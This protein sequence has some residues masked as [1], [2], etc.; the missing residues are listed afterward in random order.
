VEKTV[1]VICQ[2]TNYKSI[3]Q[4]RL[5]FPNKFQ[6]DVIKQYAGARIE[7]EL[8]EQGER[9]KKYTESVLN[10]IDGPKPVC[11]NVCPSPSTF[12]SDKLDEFDVTVMN[13]KKDSVEI[14]LNIFEKLSNSKKL[15]LVLILF[16]SE[17]SQSSALSF[18]RSQSAPTK[19]TLTPILF[20]LDK[21][22]GGNEIRENM[23][24]GILLGRAS[25][26]APPLDVYNKDISNLRK[27]LTKICS[28]TASVAFVNEANY[29]IL[30]VHN[31]DVLSRSVSYFADEKALKKFKSKLGKEKLFK[32]AKDVFGMTEDSNDDQSRQ[33]NENNDETISGNG[34]NSVRRN[35]EDK[36]AG[37]LDI[38]SFENDSPEK[39]VD[40]WTSLKK[41]VEEMEQLEPNIGKEGTIVK[42][43]SCDEG[44]DDDGSGDDG[45]G[46]E[47]GDETGDE[48]I[49]EKEPGGKELESVEVNDD[50]M[51]SEDS[52]HD[53][54]MSRSSSTSN[55]A[56]Q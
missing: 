34:T 31:P 53:L 54:S 9:L 8:N 50:K 15:C 18:M 38:Y 12:V 45:S 44:S 33:L 32:K 7:G 29:P 40:K 37:N 43:K 22:H 11:F 13:L 5:E 28:S 24:F 39:V 21:K 51:V 2:L 35:S 19:F 56:Y 1:K 17:K 36:L 47:T 27:V 20:D 16:E 42:L 4:L 10:G 49:E 41:T 26:F 23:M 30:K 52:V 46:D 3:E 48:E 14:A 25:I 55:V 6:D